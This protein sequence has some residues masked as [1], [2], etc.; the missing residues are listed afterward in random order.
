MKNI[1]TETAK[2][3]QLVEFYNANLPTGKKVIKKFATRAVAEARTQDILETLK[4][5][6]RGAGIKR[7]WQD[8]AVKAARSTRHQVRVDGVV[9]RSVKQAFEDLGL[10]LKGHI[11]FRME[12]KAEKSIN[13]QRRHWELFEV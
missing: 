6:D 10:D 3:K 4:G 9:Y 2:T 12:L 8:P 5:A 1:N 13:S 11:K 7:S